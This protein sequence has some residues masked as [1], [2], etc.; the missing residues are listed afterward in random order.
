MEMAAADGRARNP[1]PRADL[2]VSVDARR[3]DAALVWIDERASPNSGR[4]R[5]IHRLFLR[6][7]A[8][9]FSAQELHGR[10]VQ[11]RTQTKSLVGLRDIT[12][13]D[14][15]AAQHRFHADGWD[16]GK[17]A[18]VPRTRR[19]PPLLLRLLA[20]LARFFFY[21]FADRL[22]DRIGILAT[23]QNHGE[24]IPQ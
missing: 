23:R 13:R 12:H 2:F 24:F 22:H 19:A 11:L 9:F 21:F 1:P 3:A 7:P 10:P 4:F 6:R 20:A 5:I 17:S 8:L 18:H 14:F 16:G 15:H